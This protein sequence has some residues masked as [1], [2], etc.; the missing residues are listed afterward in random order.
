MRKSLNTIDFRLKRIKASQVNSSQDRNNI[1]HFVRSYFYDLRREIYNAIKN[2]NEL[3]SL[4]ESMHELLRY[5]QRRTSVNRYKTMVGICRRELNIIESKALQ[6]VISNYNNSLGQKERNI[7]ET[8]RQINPVAAICYEQGLNDLLDPNRK[9]WRGTIVEFREGLREILDYL[10]PD[11]EIIKAPEFKYETGLKR[12][13][14][15]QKTIFILRS[16]GLK[17]SQSEPAEKAV[18][19]IE[20]AIGSLVRS[21]Y[22]KASTGVHSLSNKEEALRVKDWVT[23]VLAELLEVK[24]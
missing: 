14:M 22:D 8:L 13:T 17:K 15:R 2:D 7:L 3:K 9:S 23:V 24:R 10:A 20:E 12:P 6:L 21:V 11:Q 1:K 4:D 16:R 5:A 19:A 18:Q